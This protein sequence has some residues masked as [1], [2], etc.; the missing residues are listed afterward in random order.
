MDNRHFHVNVK[1]SNGNLLYGFIIHNKTEAKPTQ[2]IEGERRGCLVELTGPFGLKCH[3]PWTNWYFPN[4]I[5]Y[6]QAPKHIQK[7]YSNHHSYDPALD[8]NLHK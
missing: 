6:G 4:N 7:E 8:K 3:N 2:D 1:N 5:Y